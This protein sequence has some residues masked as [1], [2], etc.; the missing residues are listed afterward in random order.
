MSRFYIVNEELVN[1]RYKIFKS[2]IN[3]SYAE[4]IKWKK[5]K[6]AYSASI[7]VSEVINRV[8][9]LLKKQKE[10]WTL[11]D[12]NDA[13]KVISYISRAV[14]IK[15]SNKPANKKKGCLK[16]KNYYALKNWAYD[17]NKEN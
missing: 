11:K 4:M 7:K 17:R 2:K 13:G 12:Y 10:S 1:K 14:K 9:R 6:C 3:M 16:G 5:E 8:T 15:D